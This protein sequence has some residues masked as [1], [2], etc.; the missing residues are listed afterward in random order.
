MIVMLSG[1]VLRP[2]RLISHYQ[3]FS[4]CRSHVVNEAVSRQFI[5]NPQL[6]RFPTIRFYATKKE[7]TLSPEASKESDKKE[8]GREI[9]GM[10]SRLTRLISDTRTEGWPS[11]S[12]V[13]LLALR[14]NQAGVSLDQVERYLVT[15]FRKKSRVQERDKKM[16]PAFLSKH[17]LKKH[18][19]FQND[20]VSKF[21]DYFEN[22]ILN[23]QDKNKIPLKRLEYTLALWRL[24]VMIEDCLKKNETESL[25]QIEQFSKRIS[26]KDP[27]LQIIYNIGQIVSQKTLKFVDLSQLKGILGVLC[28]PKLRAPSEQ[29]ENFSNILLLPDI[30]PVLET[31]L[32]SAHCDLR[33]VDRLRVRMRLCQVTWEG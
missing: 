23:K 3:E 21:L 4:I 13:R 20:Q 26:S 7:N 29:S 12:N 14:C 17:I 28:D 10:P 31:I 1:R 32:D 18:L 2:A 33:S 19:S 5:V 6:Q 16:D 15:H 11:L 27:N 9:Q 24:A 25:K 22:H 30:I 8:D